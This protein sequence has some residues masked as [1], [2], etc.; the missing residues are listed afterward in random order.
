[1]LAL[2]WI[3]RILSDPSFGRA[4][5]IGLGVYTHCVWYRIQTSISETGLVWDGIF[6][7]QSQQKSFG[8][9]N[10]GKS[11]SLNNRNRVQQLLLENQN[12]LSGGPNGTNRGRN[13]VH[14]L[15]HMHI[16][17]HIVLHIHRTVVQIKKAF[18]LAITDHIVFGILH[19]LLFDELVFVGISFACVESVMRTR[20]PTI[21]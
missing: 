14:S 5:P 18:G 4:F 16:R 20:P 19:Y 3:S 12:A 13:Q 11:P 9:A 6:G 15:V 8:F 7:E 17:N 21:R 10:L 2:S 1:M